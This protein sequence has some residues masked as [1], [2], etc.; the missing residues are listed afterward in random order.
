MALTKVSPGLADDTFRTLDK[1]DGS[2]PLKFEAF[3]LAASGDEEQALQDA[4]DAL[5]ASSGEHRYRLDLEGYKLNINSP[6]VAPSGGSFQ[7]RS[8]YNGEII[9]GGSWTAGTNNALLDFDSADA[10]LIGMF[11]LTFIGSDVAQWVHYGATGVDIHY[12]GCWFRNNKDGGTEWG[13]D[14]GADGHIYASNCDFFVN[15]GSTQPSARSHLGITGQKADSKVWN[16][17]FAYFKHAMKWSAGPIQITDTHIFQGVSGGTNTTSHTAG[18]KFTGGTTP[19]IVSGLYLDKCFVEISNEDATGETTIGGQIFDGVTTLLNNGESGFAF[20]RANDYGSNSNVVIKDVQITGGRFVNFGGTQASLTALDNAANF[21]Q[22]SFDNII[23]TGNTFDSS[24]TAE[25]NPVRARKTFTASLQHSFDLS[26]HLPFNIRPY[27]V[28]SIA[29]VPSS[30]AGEMLYVG[31]INRASNVV[32]IDTQNNWAGD[33]VIEVT[34][35]QED[36]D[37]IIA[38]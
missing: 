8:I 6:I 38:V 36:S 5:F 15:E 10:C 11:N 35:N 25:A 31:N 14:A 9:A 29:G 30:G 7:V 22:Q 33:M 16:C 4:I 19:A 13:I 32:R 27:Q 3:L 23:V 26:N 2:E 18:I 37:G 1:T 34:G 20:F 12:D 28:L 21:D 17:I 24:V